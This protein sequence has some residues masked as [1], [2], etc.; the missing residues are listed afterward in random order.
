MLVYKLN[1]DAYIKL[2]NTLFNSSLFFTIFLKLI[3]DQ[4]LNQ[5]F[6][7]LNSMQAYVLSQ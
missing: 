3:D 4:F 2:L 1:N 7:L 6:A 5:L